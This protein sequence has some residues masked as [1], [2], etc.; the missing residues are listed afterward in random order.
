MDLE[1]MLRSESRS[2]PA[3]PSTTASDERAPSVMN[4]V[5]P[6]PTRSVAAERWGGVEDSSHQGGGGRAA[7]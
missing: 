2:V 6:C 1:V 7:A 3:S 4:A 5:T